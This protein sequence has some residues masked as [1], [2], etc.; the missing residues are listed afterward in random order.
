VSP[1]GASSCPALQVEIG[2]APNR[3]PSTLIWLANSMGG[4]LRQTRDWAWILLGT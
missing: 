1:V 2:M 4:G 3:M